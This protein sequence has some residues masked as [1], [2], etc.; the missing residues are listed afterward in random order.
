MTDHEQGNLFSA[1]RP[2]SSHQEDAL[3]RGPF[4]AALA[5]A[6]AS[7]THRDSL[8][9]ALTGPWGEGKTSVKNMTLETLRELKPDA[10]VVEFNPWEWA[11]Q[12]R[13]TEA[14]F[15]EVALGLGYVDPTREG[16]ERV[17]K[18]RAYAAKL[19]VGAVAA[20]GVRS[21]VT[22]L[23]VL[24][25]AL[26]LVDIFVKDYAGTTAIRIVMAI[27]VAAGAALGASSTFADAVAKLLAQVNETR[28]RSLPETK[29]E[30]HNSLAALQ[31]PLLVVIDD[32]DRLQ[33]S[34]M[35]AVFQLVKA[36]ADFPNLV[37]LLL[38]PREPVIEAL[39]TN[40]VGGDEF[41]EK[42][43]QV[44]FDIPR[45]DRVRL[46]QVLTGGLNEIIREL[47]DRSFSSDRW[48]NIYVPGLSPFFETLRDIRRFL[49]PLS[50]HVSLLQ[51]QDSF[52]VNGVDLIALETLRVFLP[53]TYDAIATSKG[54][55]TES[56]SFGFGN[57][58]R[59]QEEVNS[60]VRAIIDSAP[61]HRR[62]A[63]RE[64][65]KSLFPTVE[66]VLGGSHYASGVEDD[67]L[68]ELRV[69][70]PEVFD[71]YFQLAIAEQDISQADIDTILK[72]AGDR[73]QLVSHLRGLE[74]RDLL[75]V[76][77]RRLESY[78]EEID[79][80][81]AVPFITSILDVGDGLPERAG[82]F[83]MSPDMH[84]IRIVHWY[85]KREPDVGTREQVLFEAVEKSDGL[86]LP[87]KKV[88]IETRRED[89]E[90]DP[91]AF[92]VGEDFIPTLQQLGRSK[93]EEAANNGT[94]RENRHL[95]YILY[96]WSEWANEEEVRTWVKELVATD[97][98]LVVFL[99]AM[100]SPVTSTAM[101]SY[102]SHV[103]WRMTLKNLALFI[104]IDEIEARLPALDTKPFSADQLLG[105][106]AML[107]ALK[108]RS[109]GKPDDAFGDE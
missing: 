53:T 45:V 58:D 63:V 31:A 86:Y 32:I 85:L 90:R 81:V 35:S 98:G 14:F 60:A 72:L 28:T 4:A 42:I 52:E 99:K 11:S 25:G 12:D 106:D 101:G 22:A 47:P 92:L 67:W 94:L 39:T 49:A 36:N 9:L 43:I 19:S 33:P 30:L 59:H 21:V 24:L 104:G 70:H 105:V 50:F 78:K 57:D 10:A 91:D 56:P 97:E 18:W 7:W 51:N 73:P 96:R 84:A 79:L 62:T 61:E 38:F 13:V 41:L 80:Q 93:I 48:I 23:F 83:G 107:R 20:K 37:Y 109:E 75:P 40:A 46:E 77:L 103:E 26:G 27:A 82:M 54:V 69:C 2:I 29:K 5:A 66:W 95:G 76:A 102:S 74:A 68:R 55:L 88:S 15:E 1:D 89:S 17:A 108:R 6:V 71:R 65:V 100:A 87:V 64:V 16:K 34:Q 8:V 3:G 44:R